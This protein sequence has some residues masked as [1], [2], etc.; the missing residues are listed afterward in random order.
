MVK[1]NLID[2][3][4]RSPWKGGRQLSLSLIWKEWR[5]PTPSS[6]HGGGISVLL[7]G[8]RLACK[9][10]QMLP[11]HRHIL[12]QGQGQGK[13]WETSCQVW[14]PA[15]WRESDHSSRWKPQLFDFLGQISAVIYYLQGRVWSQARNGVGRCLTTRD[16]SRKFLS[17]MNFPLGS[18]FFAWVK[19]QTMRFFLYNWKHRQASA[20]QVIDWDGVLLTIYKGCLITTTILS[21]NSLFSTF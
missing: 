15:P 5:R 14:V 13:L 20:H 12:G 3:N 19:P 9:G 11:D 10:H 2:S 8:C 4:T 16:L 6:A 7:Y 18:C 1:S 21:S 17:L